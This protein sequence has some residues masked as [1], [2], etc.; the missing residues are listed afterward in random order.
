MAMHLKIFWKM[1][2]VCTLLIGTGMPSWAQVQ[3]TEEPAFYGKDKERILAREERARRSRTIQAVARVYREMVAAYKANRILHAEAMS[4]E[5]DMLL[6]DPVL[7]GAFSERMRTKQENFLARV[8]GESGRIKMDVPTDDISAE[9]ILKIRQEAGIKNDAVERAVPQV[10]TQVKA[11]VKEQDQ[12][13]IQPRDGVNDRAQE[14]AQRVQERVQRNAA[15]RQERA[16]LKEERRRKKIA[17][18]QEKEK[19][20]LA[21]A[22]EQAEKKSAAT[23]R[24]GQ[25]KQPSVPPEARDAIGRSAALRAAALDLKQEEADHYVNLYQEEMQR[26]REALQ[27]AF[28]EKIEGLYRDGVEFYERRAYQF[29][30]DVF[31]ELEKL[32]PDYQETRRYLSELDHRFRIEASAHSQRDQAIEDSLDVLSGTQEEEGGQ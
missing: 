31:L 4:Q 14:K 32:S 5:L 1:M 20:R 2:I 18:R 8:Y 7:P 30:Y 6:D 25:L 24:A 19:Q 9:E 16:A 21:R 29:A 17:L 27:A 26:E 12:V 15:R 28:A 22:A 11:V 13:K 23:D 3:G 10:K